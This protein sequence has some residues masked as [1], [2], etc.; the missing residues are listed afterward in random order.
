MFHL[1]DDVK[2]VLD[3]SYEQRFKHGK[4]T[5][6]LPC[7]DRHKWREPVLIEVHEARDQKVICPK[8]GKVHYLSWSK[9]HDNLKWQQ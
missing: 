9:I 5:I 4:K 1:P 6:M 2:K 7:S 3:E 8:C